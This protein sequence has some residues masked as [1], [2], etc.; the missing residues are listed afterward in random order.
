MTNFLVNVDFPE[1]DAPVIYN[2]CLLA[3]LFG[4]DWKTPLFGIL[5]RLNSVSSISPSFVFNEIVLP[6]YFP[7]YS[8]AI[9]FN[10]FPV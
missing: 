5:N 7:P 10:L 2:I 1:P 3:V 9:L 8:L 4:N 6:L